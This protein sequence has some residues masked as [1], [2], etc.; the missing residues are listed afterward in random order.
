MQEPLSFDPDYYFDLVANNLL[1]NLGENAL[2]YADQ[3]LNKMRALGDEEGFTM[4]LSIHEHLTTRATD[5]VR[6]RNIVL[7]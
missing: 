2:M 4:W 5:A 7:H 1:Q 3:A 6:P